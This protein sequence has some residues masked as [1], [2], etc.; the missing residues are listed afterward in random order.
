MIRK[1]C[2]ELKRRFGEVT[3][4]P[5]RRMADQECEALLTSLPGIGT[6][7]A[8]CVMMYSLGRKVF[9]VDTHCWRVCR[10]LG[11]VRST[12]SDGVCSRGDMERL[13]QR[14]PAE[15]RFSLHVNLISLG[16]EFCVAKGPRCWVCPIADLCPGRQRR[17]HQAM[18]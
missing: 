9:P 15:L 18:G 10:R 6:K 4:A 2:A 17:G 12:S 8:R 13:Q 16:R 5:L 14:I 1:I 11:W 3:L 7:V